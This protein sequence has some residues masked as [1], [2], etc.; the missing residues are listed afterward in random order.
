MAEKKRRFFS[1][2]S[3]AVISLVGFVYYTTVF[4]FLEEWLGLGTSSG[5]LNA[6]L[7]SCLTV[8]SLVSYFVATFT[9]PGVVPSS[10]VPMVE[11]P[12]NNPFDAEYCDRC[13]VYKPPRTHHCQYCKRCV[14][15]MDHHCVWMDTC[16]GYRNH[17]PFIIFVLHATLGSCY[18]MV[19]FVGG[20]FQE[21]HDFETFFLKAGYVLFGFFIAILSLTMSSF[22]A[23][24]VYLLAHNMTTIEFRAGE[25]ARWLANRRGQHHRHPFDLGII[26]NFVSVFGPNMCQWLCPT[27]IGHLQDG[28]QFPISND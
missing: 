5:I 12:Q 17:K 1:W 11:D 20:F 14:L 3:L 18:A 7:F 24:N 26:Q 16:V 21:D 2:F 19:I 8:M 4:I 9:D 22:F 27:S 15:K 10:F 23:W 28:T 25:R 13:A 6:I